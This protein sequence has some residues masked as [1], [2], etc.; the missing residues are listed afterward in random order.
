M[1]AEL[2]PNAAIAI[3]GIFALLTLSS[4]AV[5]TIGRIHPEADFSELSQRTRSWWLM[6]GMLA[7]AIALGRVVS[8]TFLGFVAF[9]ALKEY[10][11]VI[12][13]RRADREI[14]LLAY[15]AIPIQG[16]LIATG[17]YQLFLVFVPIV[18]PFVLS[19]AMVLVGHTTGFLGAVSSL[20]LGLVA[21]VFGLGHLSALLML[22]A[23]GNPKGGGVGLLVCLVFLVQFNDVMQ[24]VVGKLWGRR[25][26]LP[27]VSPGKT[28]AGLIGGLVVTGALA[29][30]VA[31]WLTPL[32][33]IEGAVLGTSIA[34]AGVA[35]DLMVSAIK[36][37]LGIKN[38]GGALP[39]HGGVLD[40]IDSLI[41][42][43]PLFFHV[44]HARYY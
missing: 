38:T 44:V 10:L 40:R 27:R 31:Y 36:R 9:L 22:P 11:S 32:S 14:L 21:I 42:A 18:M 17:R 20:H 41:F 30:P 8:L 2:T 24:Y 6:I 29:A 26:L 1:P 16:Y 5:W 28:V 13:T 23:A 3:A 43:A 25:R 19:S 15:A 34:L 35:G 39:G 33:V 4:L 7:A 37:D 12:P